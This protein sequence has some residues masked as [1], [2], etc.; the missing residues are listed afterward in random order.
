MGCHSEHFDIGCI[1]LQISLWFLLIAYNGG[2]PNMSY[3][4]FVNKENL[5]V[6]REN[7]GLDS[8]GASKRITSAK[9]N[10]VAEWESG[11][12]LPT[13]SQIT[14]L[15]KL[16]DVPE[17]LFFSKESLPQNKAV[18][19]YR[20]GSNKEGDVK[21]KKLINLVITRQ[22]WLEKTLKEEGFSKN[23]LQ[24]SG[25]NIQS[26]HELAD[27]IAKKLNIK[28]E[29]IKNISGINARKNVLNYLLQK[30]EAQGVFIGKTVSFHNLKVED[31]RGLFVSNDYCPF[32]VINRKD[33]TSAQI[34]SF[35]HELAH[36]FRK[37]DSISNSLDFRT[38]DNDLDP[39]EIF[40]NKV[41]AELLLPASELTQRFYSKSDI[42][43]LS[44]LYKVSK[45]FIFYRLKDLGKIQ[46][47]IQAYLEK[48]IKDETN[49]NVLKANEEKKKSGGNY[50][51]SMRDSNGA[52]F[53]KI[54]SKSYL[55]NKID[56]VEASNLLRFSAE[57][58]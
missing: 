23:H 5:R 24:G 48:E 52:L 4:K 38:T 12:S 50:T 17:I 49:R 57:K 41:A 28:V 36:L 22:R 58:V 7:M 15:S 33:A 42:D 27:F 29:D 19:D 45:I 3:V 55:E 35:I 6:A 13:W 1:F 40:C 10:L 47:E 14:K 53:N 20:V 25:K 56:Y 31:M 43:N 30:A 39:E 2:D 32:I 11:D 37:T 46:K 16:Y 26:P 44:G 9:K 18:P 34:F 21:I 8:L 51:N 54:V